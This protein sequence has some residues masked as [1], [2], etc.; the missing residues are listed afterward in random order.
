MCFDD[1]VEIVRFG[2]L[3][4]TDR[5]QLEGDEPDPSMPRRSN[6]RSAQR[7][8][9]SGIR[10]D[11][12]R[13]VAS[14]G[15]VL[16]DVEVEGRERVGVLG[17]GG[18]IVTAARRGQGLARRVVE[19]ALDEGA[20]LGPEY[21]LLFCHEDRSG[22]YR[23]LGFSV[24]ESPL[25]VLR[26]RAAPRCLP[27]TLADVAA[28]PLRRGSRAW[29]PGAA[30][31]QSPSVLRSK[32]QPAARSHPRSA[33]RSTSRQTSSRS[34]PGRGRARRSRRRRAARSRCR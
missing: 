6:P 22:L 32:R 7:T 10:D 3:T 11:A 34:A 23:K 2:A 18:V 27:R 19:E 26:G 13:L 17:I 5:A 9:T 8:A 33:R 20:R 21:A 25:A 24:L 15:F 1:T 28:P 16:A 30:A 4:D 31:L 29:P 12:G 14:A